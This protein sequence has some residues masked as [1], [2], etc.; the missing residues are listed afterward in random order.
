[1]DYTMIPWSWFNEY[2]GKSTCG[3][4]VDNVPNSSLFYEKD[5][6]KLFMFDGDNR[7]WLLQG[8]FDGGGGGDFDPDDFLAASLK[9]AADGVAELDENGKVPEDQL[10]PIT[11]FV[12]LTWAQY[13]ALSEAEKNNGTYY[14]IADR[15]NIPAASGVSF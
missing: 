8:T 11:P 7:E 1:M 9:G 13:E 15:E 14:A 12:E 4:P 6:G 5:T 10:P 2:Y 3:K